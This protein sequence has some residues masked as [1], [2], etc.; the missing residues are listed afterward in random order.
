MKDSIHKY[1]IPSPFTGQTITNRQ[2]AFASSP[3]L[4]AA[5]PQEEIRKMEVDAGRFTRT[6]TGTELI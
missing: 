4:T 2:M 1:P 5:N 3:S 6:A